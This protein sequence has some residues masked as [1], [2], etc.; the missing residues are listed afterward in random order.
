MNRPQSMKIA[1][2]A[3]FGFASLFLFPRAARAADGGDTAPCRAASASSAPTPAIPSFASPGQ[4][5]AAGIS[6]SSVRSFSRQGCAGAVLQGEHGTATVNGDRI[7]LKAG[8]V[9]VNGVSYGSVAPAQTVEYDV[10]RG[11]RTLR[12]DGDVRM[13]A[14]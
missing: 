8:T 5:G 11:K 7:E 10:A 1:L 6:G 3:A 12:V 14:Q 4:G 13:P 9:Y 2:L